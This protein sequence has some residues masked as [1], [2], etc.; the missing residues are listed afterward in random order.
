MGL[1]CVISFHQMRLIPN[2]AAS[3]SAHRHGKLNRRHGDRAL[4]YGDRNGFAR[5]PLFVLG[6]EFPF[7]GWHQ[8]FSFVGKINTGL[9]ADAD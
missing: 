7:A 5:I 8:T 3:K 4:A 2:S 9:F 1:D 6:S